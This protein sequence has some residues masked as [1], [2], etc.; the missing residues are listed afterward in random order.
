M[1]LSH[2]K[3]GS[4]IHHTLWWCHNECDGISNHQPQDCLLNRWFR[5]SS[6]KTSKL[7]V[8]GLCAGNSSVISEFTAQRSSDAENVSIWWHHH[9]CSHHK[10]QMIAY[11][12]HC[13][14][15]KQ[16]VCHSVII[17]SLLEAVVTIMTEA[18]VMIENISFAMHILRVS[19]QK[20]PICHA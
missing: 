7:R 2:C 13:Y 15:F 16:F 1:C 5:R 18:N 8:T 12:S 4:T 6:K 14:P 17:I 19:C 3:N 10:H 9:E 20:G 11:P